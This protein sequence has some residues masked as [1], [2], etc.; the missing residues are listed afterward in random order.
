MGSKEQKKTHN[1]KYFTLIITITIMNFSLTLFALVS[2]IC[3]VSCSLIPKTVDSLEIDAFAG[4]WYQMYA[5]LIPNVTFEKNGF[6]VVADYSLN[7]SESNVVK[8]NV[9]NSQR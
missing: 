9:F 7:F 4:R 1:L 6:C 8:M 2:L 3:S 5:S